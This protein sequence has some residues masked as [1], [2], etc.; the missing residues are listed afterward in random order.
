LRRK[1]VCFGAPL[2]NDRAAPLPKTAFPKRCRADII[3]FK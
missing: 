1:K 3:G 2:R